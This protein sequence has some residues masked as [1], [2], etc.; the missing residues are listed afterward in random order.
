MKSAN[1]CLRML[2]NDSLNLNR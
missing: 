1:H 2:D